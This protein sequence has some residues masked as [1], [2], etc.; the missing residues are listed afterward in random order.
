MPRNM[1]FA[2]TTEQFRNQTKTV[3]RRLG[4]DN[5]KRGDILNGCEKCQ[6]LKKGEKVV[7]LGQIRIKHV[8]KQRLNL[9]TLEDCTREGFPKMSPVEFVRFFCQ[10][11]KCEPYTL[12]NRIEFEYL[13]IVNEDDT[14][15]GFCCPDFEWEVVL[16]FPDP[17][18][19]YNSIWGVCHNPECPCREGRVEEDPYRGVSSICQ[20]DFK[21]QMEER[22]NVVH[23]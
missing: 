7:K 6:G 11:N 4:W 20:E 12:V 5:L 3:T 2:L 1:S 17:N 15:I 9:V 16:I 10:H 14:Y 18:P 8:T 21:E 19:A 13:G 22:E 23:I